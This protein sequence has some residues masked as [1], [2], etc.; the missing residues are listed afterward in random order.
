MGELF[1]MQYKYIISQPSNA[2]LVN[3]ES[4]GLTIS[5]LG[6][7]IGII[8]TVLRVWSEIN[9]LYQHL[10]NQDILFKKQFEIHDDKISRIDED[11]KQFMQE[12]RDDK[13]ILYDQLAEIRK[14]MWNGN[15]IDKLVKQGVITKEQAD[16]IKNHEF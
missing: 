13:A 4:I 6:G 3:W 15:G 7:T 16:K 14:L 11:L 8:I 2:E 1:S 5:I 12:Y 9:S 10:K